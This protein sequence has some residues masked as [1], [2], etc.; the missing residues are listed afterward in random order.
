[1]RGEKSRLAQR[2]VYFG[3]AYKGQEGA[4]ELLTRFRSGGGSLGLQPDRPGETTI[5]TDGWIYL[6]PDM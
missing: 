6:F 1:M 4:R 2:H 3:H 5:G